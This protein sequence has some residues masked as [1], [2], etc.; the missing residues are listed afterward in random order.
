MRR[1]EAAAP[2]GPLHPVTWRLSLICSS[3]FTATF[4]FR[5]PCCFLMGSLR[6]L[7]QPDP[8]PQGPPMGVQVPAYYTKEER[9]SPF[10]LNEANQE[11]ETVCLFLPWRWH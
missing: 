2:V 5:L 9:R 8:L 1:E 4:I 10:L 11:V 6:D 7:Q 3:E